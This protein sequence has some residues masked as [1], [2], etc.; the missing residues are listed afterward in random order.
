MVGLKFALWSR[1]PPRMRPLFA[2]LMIAVLPATAFAGEPRMDGP[3]TSGSF[4]MG[5]SD[6]YGD[7][8]ERMPF[9]Q[10][11]PPRPL[12]IVEMDR[13]RAARRRSEMAS[14]R[15]RHHHPARHQSPRG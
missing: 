1:P 4:G 10:E 8:H 13:F 15:S 14:A 12:G 7:V 11:A 2:V 3:V 5:G 6:Y 9:T